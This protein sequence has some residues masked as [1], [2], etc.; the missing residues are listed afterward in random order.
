MGP[1]GRVWLALLL[2]CW[3]LFQVTIL[4]G[5][6][7]TEVV[8]QLEAGL[9]GTDLVSLRQLQVVEIFQG[10]SEAESTSYGRGGAGRGTGGERSDWTAVAAAGRVPSLDAEWV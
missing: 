10:P 3:L 4:T 6:L 8:S 7:G 1:R 9:Q 5:H 2:S